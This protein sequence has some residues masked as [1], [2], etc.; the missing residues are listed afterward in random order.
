MTQEQVLR[1]IG[2]VDRRL[3]IILNSGINWEPHYAQEMEDIDKEI[4]EL[5]QMIN[6]EHERRGNKT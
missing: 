3:Q 6:A 2:L 1:Y 5:R 4:C